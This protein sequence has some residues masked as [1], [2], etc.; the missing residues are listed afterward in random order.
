MQNFLL[1]SGQIRASAA[2]G[3]SENALVSVVP[4]PGLVAQCHPPAHDGI[5]PVLF[6]SAEHRVQKQHHGILRASQRHIR[7]EAQRDPALRKR[8]CFGKPPRLLR[9]RAG[10][11]SDRDAGRARQMRQKRLQQRLRFSDGFAAEIEKLHAR[12]GQH[13]L[14][15]RPER[16]HVDFIKLFRLSETAAGVAFAPAHGPQQLPL[17]VSTLVVQYALH[18]VL[19]IPAFLRD[20]LRHERAVFRSRAEQQL[21]DKVQQVR[22]NGLARILVF[23]TV[24]KQARELNFSL[25]AHQ[26]TNGRAVQFVQPVSDGADGGRFFA[27]AQEYARQQR[28]HGRLA[29]AKRPEE[30]EAEAGGLEP[31]VL[32]RREEHARQELFSCR[33]VI[34]CLPPCAGG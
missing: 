15:V 24:G 22:K 10:V 23:Q 2:C 8:H 18:G 30:A 1:D 20:K 13:R 32:D 21:G 5:E 4:A 26:R 3:R 14:I 33:H 27:A 25:F 34:S 16:A 11:C 29:C 28:V 12:R 6:T 19:Q 17:A 7:A 31:P 9:Q